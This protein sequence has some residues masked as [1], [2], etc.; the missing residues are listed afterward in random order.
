MRELS[1]AKITERIESKTQIF[2]TQYNKHIRW[3]KY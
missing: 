2:N 3:Q 1:P